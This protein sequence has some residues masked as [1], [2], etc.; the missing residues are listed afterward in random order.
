MGQQSNTPAIEHGIEFGNV[1]NVT[2]IVIQ[3]RSF[4]H[5]VE[6][7]ESRISLIGPS[8]L[9]LGVFNPETHSDCVVAHSVFPESLQR[10]C[11]EF[12]GNQGC[13]LVQ[14]AIKGGKP[15]E[16]LS[17]YLPGFDEFFSM[18]YLQELQR[19]NFEKI[20]VV[21]IVVSDSVFVCF[22]GYNEVP[23]YNVLSQRIQELVAQFMVG[24]SIKF[25]LGDISERALHNGRRRAESARFS[26]VEKKCLCWI[27]AGKS[28]SDL[29]TKLKLSENTVNQYIKNACRKLQATSRSHAI[30]IAIHLGV[31]DCRSL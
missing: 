28:V 16:A 31:V 22:I 15:F 3:S 20:D 6:L 18:Q 19:L 25:N 5:A 24:L 26:P 10:M 12:D 1:Q 14:L 17:L 8:L 13:P 21:P 27:A 30:A 7:L 4:L 11:T 9:F 29:S 2:D 23:V